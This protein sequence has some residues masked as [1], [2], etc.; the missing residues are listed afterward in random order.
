MERVPEAPGVV[1]LLREGGPELGGG[2]LN[3]KMELSLGK[4][5]LAGWQGLC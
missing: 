1:W 4:A 2:L 5:G 3:K